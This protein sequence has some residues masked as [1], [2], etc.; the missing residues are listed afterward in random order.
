MHLIYCAIGLIEAKIILILKGFLSSYITL[1]AS[2]L[3]SGSRL[4]FKTEHSP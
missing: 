2:G 1:F 4:A 3:D